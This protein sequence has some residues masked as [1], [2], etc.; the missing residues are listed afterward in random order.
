MEYCRAGVCLR[1]VVGTCRLS[2]EA[3]YMSTSTLLIEAESSNV[4]SIEEVY[5][6]SN[7]K[8]EYFQT[9]FGILRSRRL[10]EQVIEKLNLAQH[11]EFLPDEGGG[12]SWR[13][14]VPEDLLA[15]WLPAKA[16]VEETDQAEARHQALISN[17]QGRLSI[18]P[19]RKSYLVNISFEANG[20]KLAAQ[21]ANTLA[22]IYI[23]SELD[24]RLQMTSKATG[25]L[26][27]RL[28]GLRLKLKRSEESLQHFRER[29]KLL[30]AGAGSALTTQQISELSQ[31]LAQAR[32][33]R[34][35]AGASLQAGQGAEG[36]G[37]EELSLRPGSAQKY[38]CVHFKAGRVG[39]PAQG[40]GFLQTL[41]PQA[42][43][44]D[45]GQGRSCGGN[46]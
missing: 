9:Q 21:V 33:R 16:T 10:A 22:E 27:S 42:P 20:R 35:V 26:T 3:I 38:P 34:A 31:N 5:G 4:V 6:I 18:S 30:E 40:I 1:T 28:E 37:V 45:S 39:G 14:L 2:D 25:W 41:W 24:A 36:E 23:E 32:Q 15:K 17:F 46:I 12:F 44:D 19:V 13:S 43:Q 7:M 29:E 8:A 11:P